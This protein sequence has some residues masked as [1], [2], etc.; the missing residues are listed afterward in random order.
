MSDPYLL[1][2]DRLQL[3]TGPALLGICMAL[4]GT[5]ATRRAEFW[6][7]Y[8]TRNEPWS[9]EDPRWS[10]LELTSVDHKFHLSVFRMVCM[11]M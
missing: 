4:Q 6:S 1:S 11:Y 10:R 2:T 5:P 3:I 8:E 7:L 9:Q